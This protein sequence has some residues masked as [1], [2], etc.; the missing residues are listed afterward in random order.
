M[1]YELRAASRRDE[2]WLENLRRKAYRDLFDATFG[3][4]DEERHERQFSQCLAEG[5]IS[6]VVVEGQPVGM[7]QSIE[8][9]GALRIGEIQ[10]APAH[11]NQGIGTRVLTD[12]ILRAHRAQKVVRLSV[13]LEKHGA[14]RLYRRPGFREAERS[15]SHLHLV[16]ERAA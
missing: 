13:G 6:I 10:I 11:Q 8:Q 5:G 2:P 14:Y 9:P 7:I 15:S 12:L 1:K 4:W 3:R 16:C